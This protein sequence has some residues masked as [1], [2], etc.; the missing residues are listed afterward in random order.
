MSEAQDTLEKE[1]KTKIKKDIQTAV[2][3]ITKNVCPINTQFFKLY[4]R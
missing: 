2:Y 1:I 3:E 4:F